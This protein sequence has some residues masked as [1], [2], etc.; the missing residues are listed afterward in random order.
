MKWFSDNQGI[1]SIV[2]K[3][4]MKTDLQEYALKIYNICLQKNIRLEMEWIPRSLNEKAD[5]I[6]NIVDYDDWG[7]TQ[8]FFEKIDKIW[9]KHTFDRFASFENRKICRFNSKFWTPGSLGVD[10]F[11]FNWKGENNWLVPPIYLIPRVIEQL[12]ANKAVGTLVVPK[13]RSAA[14]WPMIINKC[15]YFR[16]FVV[17]HIEFTDVKQIFVN[18]SVKSIFDKNFKSPVLA[19]RI[20]FM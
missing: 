4:S 5:Y 20:C 17:D 9:G 10:A 15:G 18:G 12:R 7:V 1:I 8:I 16:S 19:L 2:A 3:G 6:S 14:F 13:W 11:T